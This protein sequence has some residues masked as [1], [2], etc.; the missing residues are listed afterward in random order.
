MLIHKALRNSCLTGHAVTCDTV[1]YTVNDIQKTTD[2]RLNMAFNGRPPSLFQQYACFRI[3]HA[4][5]QEFEAFHQ[6]INALWTVTQLLMI[7]Y[8]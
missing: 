2:S 5:P 8:G 4:S 3:L 6:S 1:E 7:R